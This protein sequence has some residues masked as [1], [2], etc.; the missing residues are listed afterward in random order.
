M[1]IAPQ[2]ENLTKQDMQRLRV[3]ESTVEKGLT[4]FVEV[5]NALYE[6]RE[7]RMYRATHKDF[8]DYCEYRFGLTS[9]RVNQLIESAKVVEDLGNNVSHPKNSRVASEL[10]KV[11]PESRKDV[12]EAA[13]EKSPDV[14]EVVESRKPEQDRASQ[15]QSVKDSESAELEAIA[16]WVRKFNTFQNQS[17]A[18]NKLSLSLDS[19]VLG[20]VR[21]LVE[22][23]D[24]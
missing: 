18:L 10:A 7:S 3:L 24:D 2:Q 14:R 11:E 5:G 6:I 21:H 20:L 19:Q 16:G 15:R 22:A 8:A 9:R 13:I 4:T 23:V 17:A 12:W 1:A